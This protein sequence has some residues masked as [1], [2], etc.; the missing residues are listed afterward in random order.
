MATLSEFAAERQEAKSSKCFTCRLPKN[1]LDQVED[2]R[3]RQGLSY[4]IIVDWLK[5]Q[6]HET[7]VSTL[8]NHFKLGH[9]DGA[10]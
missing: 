7:N 8:S 3:V 1:V 9:V 5:T 2:G 10:K 4:N 6:G